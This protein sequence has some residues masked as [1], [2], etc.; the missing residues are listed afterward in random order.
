MFRLPTKR[1]L[2]GLFCGSAGLAAFG[3]RAYSEHSPVSRP[4]KSALTDL[5]DQVVLITGASAGIGAACAWRFAE[6]GSKLVL[7][8]RREQRLNE[9]KAALQTEYPGLKVHVV[10]LSVTD[11][12]KVEALPAELPAEFRDVDILVNNAGLARGVT[13]VETNDLKDAVEVME[14]N[15]IGTIAFSRAFLPGMK[16][17]GRGHLVNMGSVAVRKAEEQN[18]LCAYSTVDSNHLIRFIGLPC[19]CGW[20]GVQCVQVRCSGLHQCRS[21][22]FGGVPH[23]CDSHF[24]WFGR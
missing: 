20:I 14:T 17:R 19:L 22:R 7:V 2:T 10:A 1:V 12:P 5:K 13:S 3:R 23:P 6:Q 8:G 18:N 11:L 9:L 21:S 15:V 16:A 4:T 24:S